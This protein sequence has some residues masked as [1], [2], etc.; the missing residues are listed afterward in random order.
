F[1][2]HLEFRTGKSGREVAGGVLLQERY[3]LRLMNSFGSTGLHRDCGGVPG[4][5]PPLLNACF[6]PGVWQTLEATFQPAEFDDSGKKVRVATLSAQ[7]NGMAIHENLLLAS[8]T[9]G[10]PREEGNSPG[11]LR[12]YGE[13]DELAFRNIWVFPISRTPK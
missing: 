11:P 7:L 5:R 9:R 2:L 3:E 6:Y 1:R 10:T 4:V 12:F 8:R 13:R